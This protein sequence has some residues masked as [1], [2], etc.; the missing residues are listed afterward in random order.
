MARLHLHFVAIK[1]PSGFGKEQSVGIPKMRFVSPPRLFL[2]KQKN[3]RSRSVSAMQLRQRS[4][5]SNGNA[6]LFSI[7]QSVRIENEFRR[8]SID[9]KKHKRLSDPAKR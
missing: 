1:K 6:R 5:R 4:G 7:G 2:R 3:L 9:C 8:D